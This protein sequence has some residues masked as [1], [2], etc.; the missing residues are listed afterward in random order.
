MNACLKRFGTSLMSL[1]VREPSFLETCETPNRWVTDAWFSPLRPR[2]V[3]ITTTPFD[4]F[5]PYS[6][7]AEAPLRTSRVS[8][9]F[10]LRSA[11][12]LTGLSWVDG[13]P[14]AAAW[15]STLVPAEVDTFEMITPSMT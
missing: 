5:E 6:A 12:R 10:G 8:M 9:S 4:A 15:V 2:L 3:V 11:T 7:A 1:N 14:P 13:L